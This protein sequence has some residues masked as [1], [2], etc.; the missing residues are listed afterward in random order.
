MYNECRR[1]FEKKKNTFI[2][3]LIK[4]KEC[5]LIKSNLKLRC[6]DIQITQHLI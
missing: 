6:I 4:T 1:I 3:K 5:L 2:A